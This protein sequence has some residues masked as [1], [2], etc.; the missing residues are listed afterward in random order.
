MSTAIETCAPRSRQISHAFDLLLFIEQRLG[1][2]LKLSEL[3]RLT[4]V[5]NILA[6]VES[7]EGA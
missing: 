1:L 7:K 6:F 3:R 2:K 4:S 5:R